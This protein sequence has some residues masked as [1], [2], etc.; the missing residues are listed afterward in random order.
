MKNPFLLL[1]LLAGLTQA[2]P[3]ETSWFTEQSG[4]YARLYEDNAAM[5]AGD[6]VITWSRGAG[7]QPQPTY[8]GVHEIARD[9]DYVYIRTSNLGFHVMGPWYNNGNLFP[10]YPA[11]MA[12]IFRIPRNPVI[13]AGKVPTGGGTIGYFV[14]GVAMFDSRDA[15]S[16]SN[17]DGEDEDPGNRATV[18]GDNVWLRDAFVN[19]GNTFDNAN[20]HQ[21]G[22]NYHYH[23]NPPGLRHLLGDSVD[24]HALSNTYTETPNGRHSPIIG[25]CRDGIPIY[26]PYGFSDPT[27]STSLVR[28]MISGYQKR[29]GTNGSTNLAATGR[30]TL[31]QWVVR[32]DPF[33]T[34]STLN[35]GLVGPPVNALINGETYVLGRYLQDYAYKGDLIGFRPLRRRAGRR[36]PRPLGRL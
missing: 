29:D 7:T 17:S 11:N 25:W 20:A 16:Y 35:P 13:P 5:A 12:D 23:A 3:L 34:T 18:D 27:D 24:Y 1:C 15:F 9:N 30:T 14:D 19:E 31:P 33:V 2:D 22:A 4:Q 6:D 26:G 32:N 28:R 21:A 8:A 36:P 10:N